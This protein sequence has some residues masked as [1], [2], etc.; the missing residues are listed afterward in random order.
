MIYIELINEEE[1]HRLVRHQAFD[2]KG[3]ETTLE[4]SNGSWILLQAALECLGGD[5]WNN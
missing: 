3:R 4:V 5:M 1:M 2:E